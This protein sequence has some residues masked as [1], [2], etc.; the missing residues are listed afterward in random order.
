VIRVADDRIDGIPID[1]HVEVDAEP[2]ARRLPRWNQ[3]GAPWLRRSS[4][5]N[6]REIAV[7]NC[8]RSRLAGLPPYP[9]D[10]VPG[11]RYHQ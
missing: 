6:L 4:G 11:L 7:P 8:S 2:A 1:G 9:V 3:V 5:E 10:L